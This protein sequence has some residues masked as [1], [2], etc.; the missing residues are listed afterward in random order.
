V[1]PLPIGCPGSETRLRPASRSPEGDE[2]GGRPLHRPPA[3]SGRVPRLPAPLVPVLVGRDGGRLA[4]CERHQAR[5]VIAGGARRPVTSTHAWRLARDVLRL[6]ARLERRERARR[7]AP[8]CRRGGAGS[9]RPTRARYAVGAVPSSESLPSPVAEAAQVYLRRRRQ[10]LVRLEQV[11]G[12]LRWWDAWEA[13]ARRAAARGRP[14]VRPVLDR[15]ALAVLHRL[16]REE[17][18]RL[19]GAPP[20]A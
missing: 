15:E 5:W 3:E 16:L 11:A 7:P 19:D 1:I 20:G 6:R 4:W 18:A 13:L 12:A 8:A 9:R 10:L 2:R 17:L 14:V